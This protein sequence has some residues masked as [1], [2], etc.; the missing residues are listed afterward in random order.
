MHVCQNR[1][2]EEQV[3]DSHLNK[4]TVLV[5][6]EILC[7]LQSN[8]SKQCYADILDELAGNIYPKTRKL[9]QVSLQR[10]GQGAYSPQPGMRLQI[11]L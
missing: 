7:R 2:Q 3:V 1:H 9:V 8:F 4:Q 6:Q 11:D 5:R 10:A